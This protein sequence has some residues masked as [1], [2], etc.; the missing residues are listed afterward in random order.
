MVRKFSS[1]NPDYV[2]LGYTD[3]HGLHGFGAINF[4]SLIVN[5]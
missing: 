1:F 4:K 3:L 2:N 5:Q